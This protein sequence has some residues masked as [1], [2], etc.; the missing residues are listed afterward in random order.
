MST[1][2][3]LNQV[4][5]SFNQPI[6]ELNF[7]RYPNL[8]GA[9]F[10]VANPKKGI[11]S[12]LLKIATA[13]NLAIKLGILQIKQFKGTEFTKFFCQHMQQFLSEF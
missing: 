7:R 9:I 5:Q 4:F 8:M 6:Q 2:K 11:P 3:K 12:Q 10:L 13:Y 1:S